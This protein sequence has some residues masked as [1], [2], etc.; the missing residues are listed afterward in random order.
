MNDLDNRLL[1]VAV[2]IWYPWAASWSHCCSHYCWLPVYLA[3]LCRHRIMSILP[4]NDVDKAIRIK[5][6]AKD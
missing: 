3:L 2:L 5:A 6:K 4:P 1:T